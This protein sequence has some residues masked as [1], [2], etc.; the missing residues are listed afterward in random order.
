MNE[1][2]AKRQRLLDDILLTDRN[3]GLELDNDD[4]EV[5]EPM[6]YDELIDLGYEDCYACEH[7]NIEALNQNENYLYL[8]KLYTQNAAT[9]T[10]DAIFKKIKE[11]FDSYIKSDLITIEK[12]K[13]EIEGKPIPPDNE[14]NVKDWSLECIKKHFDHH[15]SFPTDEIITQ[16]RIKRALR[17]RLTNNLVEI[18]KDG[19]QKFNGNNIKLVISL[20][21]EIQVLLKLKKD[22]SSMVGYNATLDF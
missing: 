18:T 14:L 9:I 22:I 2:D 19:K 8:M 17:A 4:T 1:P 7:M 21:K 5:T 11:Y 3:L 20:D 16:L 13:L 6:S 12:A 10:R 15:T